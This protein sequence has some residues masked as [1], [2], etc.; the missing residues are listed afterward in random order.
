[1]AGNNGA[2]RLTTL[3]TNEIDGAAPLAAPI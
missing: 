1:M 2:A 3:T